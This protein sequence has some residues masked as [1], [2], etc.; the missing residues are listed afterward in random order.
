MKKFVKGSLVALTL[1]LVGCSN[2]A[3]TKKADNSNKVVIGSVGSD[4]QIWKFIASSDLA[5]KE[6]IEIE[7]KEIEGGPQLNNAT[8]DGSVDVNAFQS[9]GYLVSYNSDSKEKLVPVAT[10]Y[11]EPMGIYSE[12][13][14]SLDDVK[15]GSTVAIADNPANT[16][17]ALRL[18]EDAGLIKLSD[19]FNNGTGIPSDVVD[20]PKK[21]EFKLI[22]DTTGP[23]ILPDVDLV[24]IGNT[25]A[26]E[27]GLNV[28]TDSLY[29]ERINKNTKTSINALVTTEKKKDDKT[30]Q[31]LG[32]LYH[33]QEVTDYIKE[34]F[35][36]TKVDVQEDIK[37]LWEEVQ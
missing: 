18:I 14:H 5:K 29:K 22:D 8:A 15:D 9:L 17:R 32:K 23:R 3:D 13:Y 30:I 37:T 28:L 6:G 35:G 25:V 12:K 4:A 34:N 20:N 31:K 10:T 2:K 36:G 27:G 1:L 33:S 21:L 24:V 7:V 26:F 19:D 16:A 11:L